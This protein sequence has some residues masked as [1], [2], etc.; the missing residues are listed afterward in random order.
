MT[1][2]NMT[3]DSTPVTTPVADSPAL[4]AREG[5]DHPIEA[6]KRRRT[7]TLLIAGGSV[8]AAAVLAGGGIAV[9][10]AI[11][12]EMDDDND[13]AGSASLASDDD[14]A[15]STSGGEPTDIGTDSADELSE[16]IAAA[17]ASAEGDAVG[18]EAERD[19][20]WEVSFAT[21]TGEETEVRV[22]AGGTAEVVSTDAA[23]ADDTAP[24][25]VLDTETV[26]ALVS[27]AMDEVE[28]KITDLEIDDD[29]ASPYDISVV[30][31]N[32][33]ILELHLDA[34]MKVLSINTN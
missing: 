29:P 15:D 9:G 17:S 13:G 3:P 16:I 34:D 25:G 33:R 10:A 22:T 12:D 30:Q 26:D 31:A 21:S 7:R 18:M 24:L 32:G 28:G 2:N 4:P 19:G 6:P 11:A 8:L 20:S 5:H 27:A 1:E 14:D 23:D